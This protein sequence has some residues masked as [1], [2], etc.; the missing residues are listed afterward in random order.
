MSIIQQGPKSLGLLFDAKEAV[1]LA[2]SIEARHDR[3]HGGHK[4][5][6]STHPLLSLP[7]PRGWRKP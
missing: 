6:G 4:H 2:Q 7:L 5:E 3:H 1:E